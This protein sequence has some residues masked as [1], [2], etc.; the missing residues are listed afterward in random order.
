MV[1]K[2]MKDHAEPC[3]DILLIQRLIGVYVYDE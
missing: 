1:I 3:I 2:H